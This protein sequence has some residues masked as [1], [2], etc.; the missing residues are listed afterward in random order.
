MSKASDMPSIASADMPWVGGGK[1]AAT[2]PP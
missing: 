1:L 2:P